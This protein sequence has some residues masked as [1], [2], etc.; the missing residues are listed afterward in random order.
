MPLFILTQTNV[1]AAKAALRISLPGVRSGHL[2][3][4]LASS[5]GFGTNA[6]LRAA[7]AG[8][9]GKPPALAD[10]ETGLFVQRLEELG[11]PDIAADAFLAAMRED[12]LDETPYTWFRKGDRGANERHFRACEARNRPMMMV[13]MARHYA[14]LEWDCVTIDSDCDKHVSG[15]E[16]SDL[17]RIM[18]RLFQERVR[19]APGKPLFYAKAFTGSI[20]KLLPDTARQLAEDYFKL[21][22]LPLR[23]L[24]P[25]RRRAD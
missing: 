19:G 21:L 17:V 13:K 25:P 10:A 6:A 9:T 2:T 16:S 7:I 3:E 22:Y 12:V 23:D 4:A 18:H 20:K 24:P 14:E 5:L 8:E 15:P 11:Y 1:D